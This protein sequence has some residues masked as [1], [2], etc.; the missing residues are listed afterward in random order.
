L[1]L[2]QTA[3]R[4]NRG[5]IYIDSE[6]WTF[7]LKESDNFNVNPELQISRTILQKYFEKGIDITPELS[8]ES[9]DDELREK[10]TSSKFKKVLK[11]EESLRFPKVEEMFKVIDTDTKLVVTNEEIINAIKS[12]KK[13][14]WQDIQKHSVRIYGYNLERYAIEEFM[15]GMYKWTLE[16]DNFLGIMAGALIVIK[17]ING[18]GLIA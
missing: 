18:E 4:V 15:P 3:G 10:G 12:H 5:G 8:T 16:Y 7:K 14:S 6:M 2:L 13:V 9:I 1:S 17:T 11:Y